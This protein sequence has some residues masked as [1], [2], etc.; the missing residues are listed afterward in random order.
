MRVLFDTTALYVAAGVSD[1]TFTPKVQRLL[2]D[3]ETIR[4]ISPLSISEIAI[5]ANKGLTPLTQDHIARLLFDLDLA[6]LPLSAE[7]T[8]KLFGL[9]PHHADPFD[10]LLISTA[11]VENLPIVARDRE[12]KNYKGLR[13]IW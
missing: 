8:L 4:M 12:F 6:I 9:P 3:P 2:E 13:V 10:R 7:H 1:L 5:K 11:L